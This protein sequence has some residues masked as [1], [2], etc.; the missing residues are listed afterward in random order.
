MAHK[1][2]LIRFEMEKLKC[3][4]RGT[5]EKEMKEKEKWVGHIP[6]LGP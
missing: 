4:R 1:S 6:W 2:G 5:K 3:G